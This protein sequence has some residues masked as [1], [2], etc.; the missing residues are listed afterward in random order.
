MDAFTYRDGELFAEGVALSDIAARFDTPTYVYSRAAI[1]GAYRAY[2]D[3]LGDLPANSRIVRAGSSGEGKVVE[4]NVGKIS[5]GLSL[6]N[7]GVPATAG[8]ES[9]DSS[10]C[11]VSAPSG[12]AGA[13]IAAAL[14][15]LGA[16]VRRRRNRA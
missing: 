1:E 3:A 9:S 13:A 6:Y 4:D 5:E 10:G 16:L 12:S 11:A 14:A 15:M 8:G 7:D 2:A